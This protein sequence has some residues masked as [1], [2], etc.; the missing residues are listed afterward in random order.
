MILSIALATNHG[1][2]GN[3]ELEPPS[4][5]LR[6]QSKTNDQ[7]EA[8]FGNVGLP[9][10][11]LPKGFAVKRQALEKEPWVFGKVLYLGAYGM[12]LQAKDGNEY[13]YPIGLKK[14]LVYRAIRYKGN[15]HAY[16]VVEPSKDPK[17]EYEPMTVSDE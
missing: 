7:V 2:P 8:Y 14:K 15:Y 11:K 9:D 13:H 4:K 17:Y 5:I 6:F 10:N 16:I 1:C 3:F 12:I